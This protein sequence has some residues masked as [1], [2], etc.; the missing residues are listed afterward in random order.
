TAPAAAQTLATDDPVLQDIWTEAM[1]HSQLEMLAHELLD[2]IGPRLTGS[3]G[4]LKAHDWAA[5]TFQEWGIEAR[6]EQWGTWQGWERGITHIDL[7]EPRVR[8]LEGMMLAWSPP[9]SGPVRGEAVTIPEVSDPQ[10][11]E[12]WLADVEGKF[13]LVS[14][15][16]PSGRPMENW[17]EYATEKSLENYRTRREE[18]REAWDQRIINAGFTRSRGDREYPDSGAMI[19]ALEEAGAAGIL[20]SN[21]SGGWGT[22]R[23]FDA[24]TEEIPSL[25]LGLEHYT[26]LC[27]LAE[28]GDRPIVEVECEARFTG[29]QPAFNTIAMIR[30][31]E[32]PDEYIVLSGHYDT[33]DG[34]CG[35]VDNGTG[36]LIMMETARILKKHY[37]SPKRTIVVGLWG[38]EEQGL[39]GSRAF[40]EDH[41]EII[42]G[43]QAAFNQDNGTGRV[44]NISGQGFLSAGEFLSDWLTRVP[45][46]VTG[47]IDTRFPGTPGGGGSDYASF[48]AAGVPGFSVSSLSWAYGPYTW[49]TNRDSYDKIVFDEVRN[50]VVLVASMTYLASEDPELMPR[51]KRLMP[52]DPRTGERREWPQP[53]S[54]NRKGGG[55]E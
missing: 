8:S 14:F 12:R 4:Q 15:P 41:P 40:V 37:P 43:L 18:A 27:R 19:A 51:D 11:F 21:W 13:V 2:V 32:K 49:H 33:W 45:S 17:Q 53:R 39:N 26:L 25:V 6:N 9:T 36:S 23:V 24:D 31:T 16:E 50:N 54:P 30:G 44:V 28:Y 3:P 38:S 35:A 34:S 46:E 1:D 47:H 20:T 29:E 42:E 5:A 55:G 7:V 52:I 48:V 22:Y 10:E